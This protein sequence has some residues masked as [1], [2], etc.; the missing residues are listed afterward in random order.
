MEQ[1]LDEP[2]FLQVIL[3]KSAQKVHLF[4][5][6]PPVPILTQSKSVMAVM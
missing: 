5:D 1:F 6:P 2:Y 3:G 4:P